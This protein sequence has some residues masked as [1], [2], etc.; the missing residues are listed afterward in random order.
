MNNIFLLCSIKF[1]KDCGIRFWQLDNDIYLVYSLNNYEDEDGIYL[2][3]GYQLISQHR[4]IKK[5]SR[6]Y[7]HLQLLGLYQKCL[8][9]KRLTT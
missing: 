4:I 7:A 2:I 5:I 1:V 3:K 9:R 8:R 6:D